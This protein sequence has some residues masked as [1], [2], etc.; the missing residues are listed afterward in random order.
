MW[1]IWVPTPPV[2]HG[3]YHMARAREGVRICMGGGGSVSVS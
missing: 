2:D 1:F 3:M